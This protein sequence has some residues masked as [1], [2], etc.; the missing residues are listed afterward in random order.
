[1]A[2]Q[3]MRP[4]SLDE[5]LGVV[6]VAILAVATGRRRLRRILEIDEDQTSAAGTVA[7]A[8]ADGDGVAELLVDDHVVG[9]TLGET[10]EGA[11]DVLDGVEDDGGLGRGDGQELRHVEDLDAVAAKLGADEHVVL[12]GTDLLPESVGV[13]GHRDRPSP[14]S[15]VWTHRRC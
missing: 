15:L 9:G 13:G 10:L 4:N 6:D 8:G 7:G 5:A 14:V 11:G 3:S 1:L 12:V 2:S